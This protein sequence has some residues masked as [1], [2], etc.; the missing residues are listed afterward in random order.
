MSIG[1]ST[2]RRFSV[3]VHTEP[4][5]IGHEYKFKPFK[6]KL[7]KKGYD[8]A[9]LH[10]WERKAKDP[11]PEGTE[12]TID[13]WWMNFYGSYYRIEYEGHSYDIKTTSI[14]ID[15]DSFMGKKNKD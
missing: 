12:V 4:G 15:M 7:V 14:E 11:I 13:T 9:D 3:I 8:E 6:A 2:Y 1:D 5:K 10:Y